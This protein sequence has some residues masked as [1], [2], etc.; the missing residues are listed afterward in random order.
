MQNKGKIFVKKS[1]FHIDTAYDTKKMH[2]GN[3]KKDLSLIVSL[4][5][6]ILYKPKTVNIIMSKVIGLVNISK[7]YISMV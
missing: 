1:V 4:L 2:I 5:Y 6:L 7:P 3:N